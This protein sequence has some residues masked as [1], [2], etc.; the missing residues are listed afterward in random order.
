MMK[1]VLNLLLIA[2]FTNFG[3]YGI[4]ISEWDIWPMFAPVLGINKTSPCYKASLQ[5]I[6]LLNESLPMAEM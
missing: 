6:R 3:V 5:Y 2:T 4:D 1:V